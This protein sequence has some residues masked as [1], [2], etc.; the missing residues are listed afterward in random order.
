MPT[1]N[2]TVL[3]VDDEPEIVEMIA[4]MLGSLG[5]HPIFASNGQEALAKFLASPDRYDMVIV[6]QVMPGMSGS[7]L[8][9]ELMMAKPDIPII[10][11]TGFSESLSRD[12]LQALGISEILKKPIVMKELATTVRDIL[13]GKV[14][15]PEE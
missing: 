4:T 5:Y 15:E 11:C 12:E 7:Q 10:L 13:D 3:I 2:E 14:A 9:I 8:S 6:D 1:G